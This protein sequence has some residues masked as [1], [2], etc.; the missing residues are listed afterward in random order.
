[1]SRRLSIKRGDKITV[2][3]VILI[4]LLLG[5]VIMDL[6]CYKVKNGLIFLGL[7]L[8]VIFW[9]V[10]GNGRGLLDGIAGC[11]IPLILLCPLFFLRALGGGDVKLFSVIGLFMGSRF[12]LY[13]I[14]YSFLVGSILSILFLIRKGSIFSRYQYLIQYTKNIFMQ[15][16]TDG[17]KPYYDVKIQGYEGVIHFT[18]AIFCAVLYQIYIQ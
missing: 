8:G 11:V 4:V 13:S 17:V 7:L 9:I 5:A 2:Q 6:R 12:V 18:V 10:E 16:N 14:L 15:L 3:N 1:M